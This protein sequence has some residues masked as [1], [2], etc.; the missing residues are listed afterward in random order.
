MQKTNQLLRKTN[1]PAAKWGV[2]PHSGRVMAV[3]VVAILGMLFPVTAFPADPST[4]STAIKPA[5]VTATTSATRPPT[6]VNSHGEI[7][8][9]R[10]TDTSFVVVKDHGDSQ[11]VMYYQVDEWGHVKLRHSPRFYYK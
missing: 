9:T 5:P 8:V 2:A 1:H 11:T 3:T 6:P 7:V 10:L 4:E